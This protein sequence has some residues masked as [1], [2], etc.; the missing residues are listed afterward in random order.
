MPW[1]PD[2]LEWSC[3]SCKEVRPDEFISVYKSAHETRTFEY[4]RNWRY[5]N[6]RPACLVGVRERART[7]TDFARD[8]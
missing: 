8:A 4:Q 2:N 3:H 7:Y 1:P 6:D 5:C